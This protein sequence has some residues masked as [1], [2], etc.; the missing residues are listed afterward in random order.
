MGEFCIENSPFFKQMIF[1]VR[2]EEGIQRSSALYLKSDRAFP[3]AYK[4]TNVKEI[5]TLGQLKENLKTSAFSLFG[6]KPNPRVRI[7]LID[8]LATNM[9]KVLE[10]LKT[11]H[12]ESLISILYKTP[13]NLLA[14]QK[15]LIGLAKHSLDNCDE[16]PNSLRPVYFETLVLLI[17]RAEFELNYMGFD[18][19][20]EEF[21]KNAK[22]TSFKNDTGGPK[23]DLKNIQQK[24]KVCESYQALLYHTL[25]KVLNKLTQKGLP[26]KERE[27]VEQFTAI[28]YFRIPEFRNR[29]LECLKKDIQQVQIPE[30]RGME[31]RLD[32]HLDDNKT[33]HLFTLFDWERVFYVYL[34]NTEKGE[35]NYKLLGEI[36]EDRDWQNRY[37]KRGIAYYLFLNE[38]AKHVNKSVVTKDHVPWQDLPGYAV[39]IKAFLIELKSKDVRRYPAPLLN[40]SYALLKNEKLL[41]VFIA[42]V[43]NKTRLYESSNVFAVFELIN[44]WLGVLKEN[45]KIYWN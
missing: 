4:N 19:S 39:L 5:K 17:H 13:E 11:S 12:Q 1:G 26:D 37:A 24:L 23:I 40:A 30:W 3:A 32:D 21:L 6:Q 45:K 35:S 34:K 22:T 20:N 8:D 10:I 18:V 42:I 9:L 33:Q 41:N 7:R 25:Q 38:W 15:I 29:L 43:Y 16:V 27:F 28:A 31:W 44:N 36:L 14:S 2:T